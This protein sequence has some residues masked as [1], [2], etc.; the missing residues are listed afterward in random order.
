MRKGEILGLAGSV[1]SGRT[2]FAEALFGLTP[3]AR[4]RGIGEMAS[5][6]ASIRR[7]MR[8]GWGWLTCRKTGGAMA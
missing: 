6:S 2:Q 4:R 3:I 7:P 1:G 8:C 5:R